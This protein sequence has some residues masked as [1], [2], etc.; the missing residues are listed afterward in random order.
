LSI[1]RGRPLHG[2]PHA[3]DV[4][5]V[6]QHR[7]LGRLDAQLLGAVF[8]GRY[9][10]AACLEA[11][12]EDN[13]AAVIPGQDLHPVPPARNEDEERAAVDIFLPRALHEPHEPIDASTQIDGLGREQDA[14]RRG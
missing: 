5:S 1:P 4:D 12:V 8:D 11:F 9:A 10:K 13:E 3:R 6:E 14:Q 2:A 7:E